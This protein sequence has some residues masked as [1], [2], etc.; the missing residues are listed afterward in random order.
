VRDEFRTEL[1]RWVGVVAGAG[2]GIAAII[3]AIL[4]AGWLAIGF[5]AGFDSHWH[6]LI[7]SVGAAVTLVMVFVIQYAS[8]RQARAILLKLDELIRTDREARDTIIGV[9]HAPVTEQERLED[10][11]RDHAPASRQSD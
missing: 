2:S 7:H 11:M 6:I 5:A 3:G 10:Q 9:E 4:V 1:T 8:H